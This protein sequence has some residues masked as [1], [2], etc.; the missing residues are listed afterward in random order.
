MSE[1]Q[2]QQ[3][4]TDRKDEEEYGNKAEA[5][6]IDNPEYAE[7]LSLEEAYQGEKLR[8]LLVRPR[9]PLKKQSLADLQRK[10]DWHVIPQLILLYMLSYIDRSNVGVSRFAI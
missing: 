1:L 10:V 7:Y 4:K 8:K 6:E 9:F 2:I 3:P 5:V